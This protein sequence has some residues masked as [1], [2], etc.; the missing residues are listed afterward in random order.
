MESHFI[1]SYVLR[2]AG[3]VD[4]SA[5][6]CETAF[7]LDPRATTAGLR[8]CALVFILRGDYAR[9]ATYAD[10][11]HGSDFAKAMNLQILGRQRREAE[12]LK[13]GSPK[14]PAWNSFDMLLGCMAHRPAPEVETL[15]SAVRESTDP[16]TNYLVAEHFAYCDKQDKAIAFLTA[17]VRGNYC[18]YP[19][20]ETDP[21]F[22]RLRTHPQ[23]D[24]VLAKAKAC[25]AA[26]VAGR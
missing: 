4:E 25:N 5:A 1:L 20:I 2:Y 8:S 21:Y 3:L 18:G 13:L 12:A 10:L 7:L 17:A 16:E 14:M 26:F 9:A 22:T 23:F 15:A 11:D 24:S 19:A 6:E